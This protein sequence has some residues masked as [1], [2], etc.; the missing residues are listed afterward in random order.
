MRQSVMSDCGL[1]SAL[2]VVAGKWKPTILWSLSRTPVRFGALRRRVIGISEK[3][4]MEELRFLQ[5]A[6][7]I[8]REVL[9]ERPAKVEYS[10]TSAGAELAVA[11]RDLAEWGR[12]HGQGLTDEAVCQ[13]LLSE[14]SVSVDDLERSR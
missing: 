5:A 6:G 10:L 4:L 8:S 11:V 3:V 1:T 7:L 2:R 13:N 14:D 9:H 12:R